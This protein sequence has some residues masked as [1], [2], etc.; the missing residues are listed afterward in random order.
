MEPTE[1]RKTILASTELRYVKG[2]GPR[3]AEKLAAQGV[4]VVEDLLY[5]LP[6]RYEDRRSFASIAELKP[7]GAPCTIEAEVSTSKLIRTRRRGFTIF[8]ARL[9]D[10]SGSVRG[11]WYNQPYLARLLVKGRRVVLYGR[12][13]LDRNNRPML[14]NAEYEL[15]DE[16]DEA[17]HSRRIVPVYRKLADLNCRALRRLI[18]AAL[19][20]LDPGSLAEVLPPEIA[21]RHGLTDRY[22]AIHDVHFPPDDVELG[23]LASG[24]TEAHRRL[25]FEEIFLL[26]LAL[27]LR[28]HGLHQAKRGITYEIPDALRTRLGKM[29]PFKL[30]GA[31]KRVLKEIAADLKS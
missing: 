14:D 18:H 12:L 1:T 22:R 10:G 16:E 25:A 17:T 23:D 29:L 20:S 9:T 24:D 4:S 15:L 11:V 30:T 28:R 13:G 19:E 27:A 7:G 26:Q 3:R 6:F 5:Y 2:V 8:E 21:G 31:Q